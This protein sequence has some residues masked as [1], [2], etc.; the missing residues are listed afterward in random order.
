MNETLV[1]RNSLPLKL[2]DNCEFRCKES[3]MIDKRYLQGFNSKFA[4]S[5]ILLTIVNALYRCS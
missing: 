1:L 3:F 5:R 4:D 2:R